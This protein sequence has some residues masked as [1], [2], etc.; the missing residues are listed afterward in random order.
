MHK[1]GMEAGERSPGSFAPGT[2]RMLLAAVRGTAAGAS[3]WPGDETVE[4]LVGHVLR[5]RG[6]AGIVEVVLASA[7]GPEAEA[8]AEA[9]PHELAVAWARRGSSRGAAALLWAA[10]RRPESVFRKLEARF[11]E[12]LEEAA[13]LAWMRARVHEPTP[14]HVAL[15]GGATAARAA[16]RS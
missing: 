9:R 12:D 6:V 14:W 15:G 2:L 8:L 13:A 10:A 11:V 4:G 3:L 7:L 16:N 5:D 1:C